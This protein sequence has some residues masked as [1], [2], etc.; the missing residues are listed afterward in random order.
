[1]ATA[2]EI[3]CFGQIGETA[4]D[5]WRLLDGN[6]PMST[7]KLVKELNAPRD[8]VMQALGWLARE[9]KI[10]IEEESRSRV[11]SLRTPERN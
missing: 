11:V 7:A 10:Q 3:D 8:V 6:G 5:I 9:D 2:T 4:G 1:M